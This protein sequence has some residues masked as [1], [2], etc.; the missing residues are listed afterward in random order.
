MG[1]KEVVQYAR[2][3]NDFQN[4]NNLKPEDVPMAKNLLKTLDEP[5]YL[6][7]ILF[8]QPQ[9]ENIIEHDFFNY[10]LSP[11]QASDP[12][13]NVA[14]ELL[15][16]DFLHYLEKNYFAVIRN[17]GS[18]LEISTFEPIDL[19]QSFWEFLGSTYDD[20]YLQSRWALIQSV[21]RL[22][23]YRNLPSPISLRDI[24]IQEKIPLPVTKEIGSFGDVVAGCMFC[25]RESITYEVK[26]EYVEFASQRPQSRILNKNASFCPICLFASYISPI[27]NPNN[28]ITLEANYEKEELSHLFNRI[29]GISIGNLITISFHSRLVSSYGKTALTYLAASRIPLNILIDPDFDVVNTVTAS[30]LKKKKILAM[31]AFDSILGYEVFNRRIRGINPLEREFK[32]A[33]WAIINDEYFSLLPSV[34]L[35]ARNLAPRKRELLLEDGIFE[36]IR[37]EVIGMEERPDIVFGTALL[38]DAFL[39]KTWK[40]TEDLKTEVRKVAYYLENPEQ[41]LYRL[42]QITGQDYTTIEQSFRNKTQFKL[43]RDLLIKIHQEEK[44]GDFEKEQKERKKWIEESGGFSYDERERLFLYHDDILKVYMYIQDL[45][46]AEEPDPKRRKKKFSDLMTRVKYALIAKR[47]ELIGGM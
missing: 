40:D 23:Q 31:K 20:F 37:N 11:P 21:Y 22:Q 24:I 3:K 44:L 25:G 14:L 34:S 16:K 30:P 18:E 43:L 9:G 6:R 32:K 45:L 8:N 46:S 12:I 39:P 19:D 42:M 5:L 2:W 13:L 47:I 17:L 36:L 38:L 28:C 1:Y 4:L 35:L 15:V 41:A 27:R 33:L 29:F 7:W 10:V 26:K